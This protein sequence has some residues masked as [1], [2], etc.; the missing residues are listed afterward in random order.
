MHS[1]YAHRGSSGAFAENTR[2]AFL[3]AIADGADGIE[4]DVHLS[5][6]LQLVCFHDASVD[7][8]SD[9]TG[10]LAG[11]TLKELRR[12]DVS[13]WKGVRIPDEFGARSEQ[14]VTLRELIG[15][16]VDS[17]RE[18]GLAVELKH[19][20]PFGRKLEER[21]LAELMG[22]GWDPDTSRIGGITVSLMSFD[23]GSIRYLLDSVPG[24][25]LCQLVTGVDE[26]AVESLGQLGRAAATQVLNRVLADG[27]EVIGS[28]AVGIAGPG[29]AF[30]RENPELVRGW[31]DAGRTVRVWTANAP[32]DVDFLADLGVQELT[33]D[34][35][36][37]VKERLA[38]GSGGPAE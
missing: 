10:A 21:V 33:S 17:G 15:L 5:E 8:T 18:L 1:V 25:H 27:L 26:D 6:D 29:V 19:P 7:R 3:Q 22:L 23:A 12:L 16:M 31:I 28:G 20:S 9:G 38:A 36:V 24:E 13:S 4:C 35:P 14:L 11:R 37:R 2:A 34:Y 32:E 30:V